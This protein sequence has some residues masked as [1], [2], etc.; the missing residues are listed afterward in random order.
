MTDWLWWAIGIGTI[1]LGLAIAYG[2]V[3]TR[4][5]SPAAQARSEEAT[6]RLYRKEDQASE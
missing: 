1:A 6:D 2:I 5:R 4:G 3:K